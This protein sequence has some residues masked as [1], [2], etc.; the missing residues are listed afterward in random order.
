[1]LQTERLM[2]RPFRVADLVRLHALWID[3][4]VRRYL[5]DDEVISVDRAE[6]AIQASLDATQALGM[7]LYCVF[8]RDSDD[9]AGF[10]GF[11]QFEGDG[12]PEL[13]FGFLSHVWGRGFATEACRSLL[14]CGFVEHGFARVVAATDT[15]NQSSVKVLRRLGMV[16]RERRLYHGLDTV[17][18]ELA[19]DE[20]AAGQAAGA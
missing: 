8:P 11:R 2:L 12:G 4:D 15:P 20:F 1:M 16:F 5:W 9:L 7:G 3:P 17:F 6:Q 19:S 10:A 13:L 14:R 18:Y